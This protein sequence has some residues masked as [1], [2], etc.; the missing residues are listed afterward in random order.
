MTKEDAINLI[1]PG[2]K[3]RKL[4]RVFGRWLV[5]EPDEYGSFPFVYIGNYLSTN[6]F[7]YM[8]KDKMLWP[9]DGNMAPPKAMINAIEKRYKKG[10]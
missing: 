1:T 5:F 4:W 6:G 10:V 9:N 3:Y 2:W 8:Y 7:V